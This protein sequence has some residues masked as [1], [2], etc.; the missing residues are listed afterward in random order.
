[1]V[2]LFLKLWTEINRRTCR[3]GQSLNLKKTTKCEEYREHRTSYKNRGCQTIWCEQIVDQGNL[4]W[5][6]ITVKNKILKNHGKIKQ[7]NIHYFF[8]VL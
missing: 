1:M 4:I 3:D 6:N 2:K 7:I 8:N 5:G